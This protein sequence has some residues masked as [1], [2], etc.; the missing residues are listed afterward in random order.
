LEWVATAY[1]LISA[2]LLIPLGRVADILGRKRVFVIGILTFTL[3][4]FLMV[5]CGSGTLLICFRIL[6]GIG[7][8]MISG[9]GMA[10][11]TSV[12]PPQGRGKALGINVAATY[13]GLTIGPFV[14]GFLTLRFGWRS[15]FLVNVPLGLLIIALVAWKLREEWA[16][17]KGEKF[18]LTGS[19]IYCFGLVAIM[20]GFT[21]FASLPRVASTGLMLAGVLAILVFVR[22]ESAVK[23]PVLNVTLF[24][25]NRAFAFSN[26]AAL[27]NYS[28]TF[29]VTFFLSLYLQY[30]K[31]LNP[32]NA[33]AVLAFGAVVRIICSPF[34]G[35]LSDRV[36][37]RI[38]SSIGM[39][40]SATAL[41]L[42]AFLNWETPLSFIV[43]DLILLGLGFSFFASPNTNAVMSSVDKRLYGVASG[44]L[45]TMRLTGQMLSMGIAILLFALYIGHAEITPD[46]FP[47]FLRSVRFAFIFF[48]MLCVTGVLAS[49]ARGKVHEQAVPAGTHLR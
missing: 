15:I 45:G 28:A 32:Q 33:G 25:R 44:T 18:D 12:F 24:R 9:T 29:A 5:L 8:A 16:E 37:P 31:G 30:I 41:F 2:M 48:S 11:L 4:S 20:F 10:L 49:L 17:A 34:A 38:V 14:G 1:L 47:A 39:A 35:R 3:A 22:W 36:E 23:N 40:L 27:I 19:T 46:Y 42:L 6:Q 26:L 43:A 21:S 13:L 7:Y